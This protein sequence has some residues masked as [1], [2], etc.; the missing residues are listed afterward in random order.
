MS[1]R[2]ILAATLALLS[3]GCSFTGH[4]QSTN[5]PPATHSVVAQ[6]IPLPSTQPAGPPIKDADALA[7]TIAAHAQALQPLVERRVKSGAAAPAESSVQWLDPQSYRLDLMPPQDP[8]GPHAMP[9][10]NA[11]VVLAVAVTSLPPATQP[12]IAKPIAKAPPSFDPLEQELASRLREDPGNLACQLD[13]QLLQL[14]RGKRVPQMDFIASLPAEDQELIQALMDALSNFRGNAHGEP[15]MLL[16]NKARP[17]IELAERLRAQTSLRVAAVS[18]CTKVQG[19][20]I[21]D[22]IDA[23]RLPAGHEN[24]VILYC[25]VDSFS[26]RLNDRHLWETNLSLD[27]TLYNDRGQRI[28]SDKRQTVADLSRN[29]RRDFFMP[30]KV[31]LPAL[32]PGHYS[33]TVTIAD[34]Q[35]NRMAEAT[36]AIQTVLDMN[37]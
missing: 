17:L 29:R 35:A 13:Y 19:F 27:A 6:Q 30:R 32:P 24:Q 23:S 1:R 22:P 25:E 4:P 2:L 11:A 15:S 21:Y 26:S 31:F 8:Q 3:D 7:G 5:P 37:K 16:A 18:L 34:Q 12:L 36:I 28:W 20:G 33:M 10:G 14:L 9:A